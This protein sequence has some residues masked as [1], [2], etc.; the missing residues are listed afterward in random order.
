MAT[1]PRPEQ[2]EAFDALE[3]PGPVHMLNLLKFKEK[4]QY[5]D[6][7]ESDLSGA[8]AYGLYGAEVT[9]LV[10]A[11]GGRVVYGGA[12]LVQ[13]IGDTPLEWDAVA[14]VEYP[15][16]EAFRGMVESEAYQAI[17]VHREA[18]LEHQLL[19]RAAAGGRPR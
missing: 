13:V 11:L 6:G 5:S 3:A 10:A 16:A 8:E 15:S 1:R 12:L 4:A 18:G 9:K 2:L 19:I 14:I 7:R 17:A